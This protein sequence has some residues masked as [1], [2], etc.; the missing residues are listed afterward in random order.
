MKRRRK[1]LPKRKGDEAPAEG[2]AAAQLLPRAKKSAWKKCWV[3]AHGNVPLPSSRMW[4]NFKLRHAAPSDSRRAAD[5][6]K[7]VGPNLDPA[8]WTVRYEP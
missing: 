7:R 5:R 8:I 6:L 2:V 3:P 4:T 1:L